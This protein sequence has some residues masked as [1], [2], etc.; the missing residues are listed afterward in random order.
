MKKER[1]YSKYISIHYSKA[2]LSQVL[3]VSG[4]RD[5]RVYPMDIY[6]GKPLIDCIARMVSRVFDLFF[7]ILFLLYGRTSTRIFAKS[8]FAIGRKG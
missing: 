4:F 5:I 7:R 8:I 6:V 1:I 3:R 2:S